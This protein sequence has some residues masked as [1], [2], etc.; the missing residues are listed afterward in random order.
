MGEEVGILADGLHVFTDV[1]VALP[2]GDEE[3]TGGELVL[4]GFED[5]AGIVRVP[6]RAGNPPGYT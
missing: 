2:P 1:G 6:L 4:D 3:V 5:G